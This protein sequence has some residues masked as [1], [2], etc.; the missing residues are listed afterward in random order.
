MRKASFLRLKITRSFFELP[1]TARVA[2]VALGLALAPDARSQNY[3]P[4]TPADLTMTLG[5]EVNPAIAID[6][7]N[8][9]NIFSVAATESGA[10]VN[11]LVTSF[12]TN[13]GKTWTTNLIATGKDDLMPAYG[14]P[15]AAF[16]SFGNLYVAYLPDV[17]EGVAVAV[18]TNFG[19]SFIL[20]T[21]LAA[22]DATETPRIAAGP[23][24]APGSVWVVYKD[25]SQPS[26]PLVVQGLLATNL[27]TNS[28]FGQPLTIPGSASGGF[29]DI[30]IGPA[31]QVLVA[32]QNNLTNSNA[33]KIFVSLNTNAFGTN[34]FSPAVTVTANA[35]GGVTYIPA[36]PT[37]IGVSANAGVAWDVDTFSPFY[38]RA[39]VVYSALA[40]GNVLNIG[41]R[42]STNS[43]ATW[44]AQE[45]VNDDSSGN[46]H[47]MPR[48]A[49]DPITGIVACSWYDCRN[50]QGSASQP[51]VQ[52][53]TG[54]ATFSDFFVTN[55]MVTTNGINNTTLNIVT[56]TL[57][58]INY[59][60]TISGTNLLG[61]VISNN[62]KTE[63]IYL[64]T[65]STAF[66]D[67]TFEGNTGTNATGT[68]TSVTVVVQDTFPDEFTSGSGAANE[69]PMV[70]TT[71]STSGGVTFAPN[72]SAILASYSINP[73]SPVKPPVLGFGSLEA[74][75]GGTL[76][77]GNYTGLA[78][79][80]GDFYPVWA[81]NSDVA[82]GNPNGPLGDFDV[83]VSQVV[84]PSADLTLF[85]TNTP[86]PVLSD[87][88][89]AYTIEAI[90]NGPSA[91]T[92]VV[93]DV[94]PANVT[95]ETVIPS[96]G[97]TSSIKGQVLILTIPTI[98]AHSSAT[99]Q[100]LVTASSSGYGTNVANISGPLPDTDPANNT[101]IL[102]ILF[103]GEELALAMSTSASNFYGG[104]IVT[105]VISVTNYGPSANGDVTISNIFSAN[106]GQLTVLSAA[107]IL[108]P[109]AL[110][111]G[112]Y[113]TNDNIL[114]L[115]MGTLASNQS[116]NIVVSALALATAPSGNSTVSVSSLDYNPNPTNISASVT[117]AMTPQSIGAG[118]SAGPAQVGVPTTFTIT[119]TNFGPS[120]Y[121]FIT[122]SNVLPPDFSTISVVQ[123]PNPAAISSNTI[124]FPVGAVASNGTATVIFTAVPQ[125]VG[126]V[127][128][129]FVAS[130]FDYAPSYT[131]RILI[132]PA[133]PATPIENFQV[134]PAASG[135]FLV[136]DTPVNATVQVEYGLNVTY[137]SVSSLG[138]PS[139]HHIVLLTGL[140]RDT[141]YYF[142]ALTWENGTLY[143]TNGA[144]ATVNTLV[145]N[146]QDASYSGLWTPS[147][148]GAGILGT[149]YQSASTTVS[150][151]TASATFTPL[152][153][154]PGNYDVSI[155]YPQSSGFATNTPVHISGATN[156][157]FDSLNQA[158][159]GGSWQPLAEDVYF[160]SGAAGNVAIFN[161]TGVTNKGVAANGM[162]W[163]YDAAQDSP[164]NGTLPAWWSTFY[165]GT[166]NVS[167]SA[168][169][170]GDG[171]SN[172][173][174]YVFGTNP[175]DASSK[176][177]FTVAPLAG[178]MVS[179]KFSPYQGGRLY[180]LLS[181]T[182]L[183][184]SQ[185]LALTNAATVDTNGNGA[186]IL[187]Q[188]NP[189]AGF[190]RLSATLSP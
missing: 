35:A 100:I 155:W 190:Y 119:V 171:Y 88:V 60:L 152:I 26:T 98:A 125:S 87:G 130:C 53:T 91:S 27:G 32:F 110:T 67:V 153:Q 132:T 105:N 167:P 19:A 7:S 6:A 68:N 124:V 99:S 5:N 2:L 108:A 25:Y 61:T 45:T 162:R 50:D 42:Y 103:E 172:F 117:A 136:W 62:A 107:W 36:Q 182:N 147:S 8:A 185:W 66:L 10:I 128:D 179:V 104:Q 102:V 96:F 78:F 40:S 145:L 3:L 156:E 93:T 116:T 146:T 112:T 11:P 84:V 34:S 186:F 118:I 114:V 4:G 47:F 43:G 169:E 177:I 137:G 30:A 113:S 92:C 31:G 24:T 129:T 180:Q 33:S 23:A 106:W 181:S 109:N 52:T 142:Q 120:P 97:A 176:L 13:Q 154:S 139:T 94:L 15:S 187:A 18:S 158:L 73:N 115:N 135:A 76:G 16:D 83:T 170:D 144:F 80:S 174:E 140:V 188:P 85:V 59:T 14:Y 134:I 55:V 173:A 75:S 63:T 166:N 150:Q 126:T 69:E 178:N 65:L 157:I 54:S 101:N 121:G 49:V 38:G 70:Y 20:L 77:F 138:G 48:I 64:S 148:S 189:A 160:A 161:N 164:T 37:G 41:F 131:N 163:V 141:N 12:S 81:D 183:D 74:N 39:Y 57:D 95:F 168:D 72:K 90:N 165:F 184:N 21:N 86:N 127:T 79:Y 28:Q 89:V 29:P 56:N 51:T 159:N 151:P 143:V 133:K 17:F 149:Y 175:T 1:W 46:S 82:G 44:S 122:V 111:T 58:G 9:A 22:A 71:I 123:S